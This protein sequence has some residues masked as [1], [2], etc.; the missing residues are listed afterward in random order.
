MIDYCCIH[1]DIKT[2][3]K[4]FSIFF[5]GVLWIPL[6][7]AIF[8]RICGALPL[9]HADHHFVP[10]LFYAEIHPSS[11]FTVHFTWRSHQ[12][13]SI[14]TKLFE[15]S[16]ISVSWIYFL[17]RDIPSIRLMYVSFIFGGDIRLNLKRKWS[18]AIVIQRSLLFNVVIALW[19]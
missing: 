5:A 19:F 12:S 1:F 18:F 9:L 3:N 10:S 14:R 16:G 6:L 13:N 4:L 7:L 15:Q 8:Q 17:E 2:K 11:R